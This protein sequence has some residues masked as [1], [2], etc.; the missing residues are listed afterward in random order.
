M[1]TTHTSESERF[2]AG[3]NRFLRVLGNLFLATVAVVGLLVILGAGS[4]HD[5]G[6]MA[7]G[8]VLVFAVAARI[9]WR[10]FRRSGR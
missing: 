10:S 4:A 3:M 5:A 8:M 6:G 9:G 7:M 1:A 2:Y